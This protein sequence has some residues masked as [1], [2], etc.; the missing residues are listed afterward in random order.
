MKIH[1]NG[2]K[3][4]RD[5]GALAH[6][7]AELCQFFKVKPLAADAIARLSNE[8]FYRLCEDLYERQPR[9]RKIAYTEALGLTPRRKPRAFKWY[10]H[11]L[12]R[13][14]LATGWRKAWLV[15]SAP[16]TYPAYLR[17][18]DRHSAEIRAHAAAKSNRTEPD[19]V[20]VTPNPKL[21]VK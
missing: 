9:A 19:H 5:R 7:Y 2:A 10:L 3:A 1:D 16:F 18:L 11:D 6:K 21:V 4:R 13:A 20:D 14:H 17:R 12:L 15:V 8:Q